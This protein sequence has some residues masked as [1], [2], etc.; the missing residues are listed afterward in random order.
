[1][2]LNGFFTNDCCGFDADDD[3]D[4]MFSRP[5]DTS[6]HRHIDIVWFC[7]VLFSFCCFFFDESFKEEEGAGKTEREKKKKRIT[8]EREEERE[9]VGS[10]SEKKYFFPEKNSNS[11][12]L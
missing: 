11:E 5:I 2:N 4:C 12:M 3:V 7:F 6:I 8:E 10:F 1:M 9:K